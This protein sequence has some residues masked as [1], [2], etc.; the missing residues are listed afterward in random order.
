MAYRTIPLDPLFPFNRRSHVRSGEVGCFGVPL[1]PLGG[2]ANQV[3]S[4]R[5][6]R[7]D[8]IQENPCSLL[9]DT[10]NESRVSVNTLIDHQGIICG[11]AFGRSSLRRIAPYASVVAPRR[12]ASNTFLVIRAVA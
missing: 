3:L 10:I 11:V 12:L 7:K 5:Y 6:V 8:T 1:F 9:R 2:E 4:M